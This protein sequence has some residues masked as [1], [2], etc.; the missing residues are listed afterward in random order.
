MSTKIDYALRINGETTYDCTAYTSSNQAFSAT[1]VG[2]DVSAVRVAMDDIA[3]IEVL[4]G[5]LVIYSSTSF[6]K[7]SSLNLR[8]GFGYND[9][10]HTAFDLIQLVFQRPD[11]EKKIEELEARN[12]ELEQEVTD[13]QLALVELYELLKGVDTN[14]NA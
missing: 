9:D 4:K 13:N 14:E 10:T 11:L 7:L 1:I 6:S 2:S 12:A 8:I 5:D 3:L